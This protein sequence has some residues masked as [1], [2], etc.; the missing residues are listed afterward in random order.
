MSV[1]R[2]YDRNASAARDDLVGKAEK[3]LGAQSDAE[4]WVFT[5]HKKLGGITPAEALQHKSLATGV[6]HS[7]ILPLR[8]RQ[9][10]NRRRLLQDPPQ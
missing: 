8:R 6:Q 2:P 9:K 3:A 10:R 4:D 5:P 1:S 7:W